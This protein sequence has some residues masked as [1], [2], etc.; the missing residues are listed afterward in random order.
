MGTI[1]NLKFIYS[2][3]FFGFPINTIKLL[4]GLK[5][6]KRITSFEFICQ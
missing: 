6:Y 1:L 5:Y 3:N 4:W 2:I